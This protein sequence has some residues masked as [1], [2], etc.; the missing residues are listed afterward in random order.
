MSAFLAMVRTDLRLHLMEPRTL[1]VSLLAPV[2]IAAFMGSVLGGPPKKPARIPVGI[3]DLD[4]SEVSQRIVASLRGDAA[5]EMRAL[6]EPAA[7]EQVRKGTL[8]AAAVIPRGFGEQAVAALFRP[9]ASRP[10]IA[11]HLD[12]SQ[13]MTRPIIDGLLAQHVIESVTASAF[14]G[15]AGSRAVD[16]LRRDVAADGTI[17]PGAR[18][19]LVT[20]FDSIQRVQARGAE[21]A[22]AAS[23]AAA[24]PAAVGLGVPYRTRSVEVAGN[25]G[26]PYNAYAHSFAGMSVQFV[27]LMG[28]ELGVA[29]LLMRKLGLWRRLQAAPVSRGTLIGARVVSGA[30]I[31]ALLMTGIYFAAMLFF[32]VRVLGSAAGFV[33][34]ILSFSLLASTMG[35]LIAAVG[36]TPGATRGLAIVVTLLLVMLGGAWIPTFL[37]PDWL[38]SLTR[39][40]PTRWAIDGLDAVTWRAQGFEAVLMPVLAMLGCSVLFA[41]LAVRG[42]RWR[43]Q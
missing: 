24:A 27:L 21:P 10:E 11:V 28:V 23:G 41:T 31:A 32:G 37:F 19:D 43:E 33:A 1:L 13:S 29:L 26:K 4:A 40:L 5:F 17:D 35:L 22:G 14:N 34:V 36:R 25:E 18:A 15:P 30:T 9:D 2:L 8:R 3:V 7:V 38:A 20:M 6:S 12:P 42:F 39:F 16:A